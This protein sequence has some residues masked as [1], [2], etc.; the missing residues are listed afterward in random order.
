MTEA[1][2]SCV[3][4]YLPALESVLRDVAAQGIERL[5]SLG[6]I[7]GYGSQPR[8]CLGLLKDAA[9]SIMGNHE[10]AILFY[11]EDFNPRARHSLEETKAAL[12]SPRFAPEE[13][14]DLWQSLGAMQ[15]VVEGGDVMYCHGS[16]R[17][18]TREYVVPSDAGNA[19]KMSGIFA[20][21][22]R[23]CFIGHSHIPHVYRLDG[24]HASP[25]DL[26]GALDLRK[27]PGQK[28]LIN[29]GS[30]GQPRDGHPGASYVTFDGDVV[31]FHRVSYE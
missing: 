7:V 22:T 17:V 3:H 20:L 18:P 29:V 4:A 27:H 12:D 21:I 5:V 10:E 25:E 19:E 11:G 30:A 8:E 26:G 6:D 9:V 1:I 23:L 15:Q 31:R 13:N 14:L 2:L 24:W 28:F 16:P